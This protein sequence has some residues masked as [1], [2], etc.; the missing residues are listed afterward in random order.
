LS[1]MGNGCTQR[2]TQALYPNYRVHPS[3][4]LEI[5][6]VKGCVAIQNGE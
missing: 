5:P 4:T 6:V 3:G 1:R 2:C